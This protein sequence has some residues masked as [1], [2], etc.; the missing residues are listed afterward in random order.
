MTAPEYDRDALFEFPCD[1]PIKVMGR[2]QDGFA[3]SIAEVMV[4]HSP[5][6][7]LAAVEMRS[8]SGGKYLSLT[9]TVR[10]L[11]RAQLDAI[12]LDLTRH[13]MVVMAL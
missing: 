9:F 4:R 8:S 6:L 13:P 5:D 10:A 3:Q 1:F 11:S 12:Y 7:D 2:T